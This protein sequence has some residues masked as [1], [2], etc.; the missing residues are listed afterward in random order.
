[1]KR[2]ISGQR[3]I[4]IYRSVKLLNFGTV[5]PLQCRVCK[6]VLIAF[7]LEHWQRHCKLLV[8]PSI[9]EVYIVANAN[10]T[11]QVRV[12][13]FF[14]KIMKKHV[15]RKSHKQF[16]SWRDSIITDISLFS[17]ANTIIV[18]IISN[19]WQSLSAVLLESQAKQGFSVVVSW[20]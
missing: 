17:N 13:I 1:M 5:Q 16:F 4:Y 15:I 12:Y 14:C 20:F 18:S 9:I 3:Q 6:G 7:L 19:K 8:K 2:L 11:G 10:G